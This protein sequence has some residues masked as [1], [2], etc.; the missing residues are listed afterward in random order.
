ML[1]FH[2]TVYYSFKNEYKL[3]LHKKL[4]IKKAQSFHFI[5]TVLT[6][7]LT[8]SL[9]EIFSKIVYIIY[10]EGPKGVTTGMGFASFFTGKWDFLAGNGIFVTGNGKENTKGNGI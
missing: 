7:K 6:N 9:V 8:V 10:K 3:K 4:T 5:K 1:L 2:V